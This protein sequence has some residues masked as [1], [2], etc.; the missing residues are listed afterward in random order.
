M[1]GTSANRATPSDEQKPIVEHSGS[2]L[3]VLAGPGTGKTTVLAL[4]I[5]Y[6]LEAGLATKDEILAVTFTTKAAAEMRQRLSDYGLKAEDQPAIA[7]LHA[8]SAAILHKY[9]DLIGRDNAFLITDKGESPMVLGDACVWTADQRGVNLASI[10]GE[11]PRLNHV[12]YE[13]LASADVTVEPTH[14]IYARYD[15]LLRYFRAIDFDGLLVQAL[16]VLRRAPTALE[17][18]RKKGKWLL[19]DEY[20]DINGAQ[21]ELIKLI[22]EHGERVFAVGDDDQ[23]I[24]S[25]R[26]GNVEFI[27]GFDKSFASAKQMLIETCRR[28]P[29]PIL[30]GSL[31]LISNNRR[32]NTKNLQPMNVDGQRIQLVLSKSENAEG[33]W[34]ANRIKE[35]IEGGSCSASDMVVL[36]TD[37]TIAE[38]VYREL[39]KQGIP[40]HRRTGAALNAPAVRAVMSVVRLTADLSDNLAARRCLEEGPISGLG[41]RAIQ[42]IITS[43]ETRRSTIWEVVSDPMGCGLSRW[44]KALEKFTQYFDGL[45]EA[46]AQQSLPEHLESVAGGIGVAADEAVRWLIGQSKD[47][48]AGTTPKQFIDQ[49][50]SMSTLDITDGDDRAAEGEGVQF[51]TT[52]LVKGLEAKIVFVIGLEKGL[53]PDPGKDEEEQRRLFYVAM[54]RAKEWLYLCTSGMR[55]V[56]GFQFY[57]PSSFLSEIPSDEVEVIKN[58]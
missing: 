44:K 27:L 22:G 35:L 54:T 8:V 19:I 48:D 42:R 39:I 34:I 53:F 3:L 43:A 26:G 13:G 20:Q 37:P 23:S 29:G 47:Q 46:Q 40:C 57:E 50:N 52:Y 56:R 55:K 24:Y 11:L 38:P 12:R 30:R 18:Y 14:S 4:R 25:W 2:P 10:R 45:R 36:S 41:P 58:N 49:M 1:S 51:F 6:L 28:C 16:E 15:D 32:R 31:G 5:L 21:H 9:A 17:E 33:R 7:T